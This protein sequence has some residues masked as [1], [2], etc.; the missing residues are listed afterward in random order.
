MSPPDPHARWKEYPVEAEQQ[1]VTASCGACHDIN[2]IL[3]GYTPESWRTVIRTMQNVE[4][5]VPADQW[6]TVTDYL[7]KNFPERA[8]PS[9]VVVPGP[10]EAAIKEWPVP[11]AG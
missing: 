11:T 3:V 6:A 5:P 1:M 9:A 4:T 10:V 2:Q 7:V 8:R